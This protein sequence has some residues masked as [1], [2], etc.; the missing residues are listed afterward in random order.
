MLTDRIPRRQAEQR[1]RATEREV[2]LFVYGTLRKGQP[3]HHLLGGAELVA[4][5]RTEACFRLIDMG[6]YPA[7]VRD[8]DC[9]VAGEIYEIDPELLPELDRYEDVPEL[10]ERVTL[11]IGGMAAE[12]YLLRPEHAGDRPELPGGDWCR[13]DPARS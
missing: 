13:R 9:A 1:Q 5:A 2:K 3:A 11:E 7:L 6:G 8:G 4:R 10:Y 12:T